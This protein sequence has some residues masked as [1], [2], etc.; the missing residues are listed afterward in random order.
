MKRSLAPSILFKKRKLAGDDSMSLLHTAKMDGI[1]HLDL[2]T[3]KT[4]SPSTEDNEPETVDTS[5]N[6]LKNFVINSS[7]SPEIAFAVSFKNTK[8]FAKTDLSGHGMPEVMY[9]ASV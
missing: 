6:V 3:T 5:N 7:G 1:N 9:S 8:R 2:F 4:P